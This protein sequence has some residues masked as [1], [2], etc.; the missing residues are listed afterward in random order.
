M[1]ASLQP[2]DFMLLAPQCTQSCVSRVAKA[3]PVILQDS[4]NTKSIYI[5]VRRYVKRDLPHVWFELQISNLL[6]TVE[7]RFGHAGHFSRG[8]FGT[9]SCFSRC[10]LA[11][12]TSSAMD[13][14]CADGH[15]DSFVQTLITVLTAKSNV[16]G[17]SSTRSHKRSTTA[18]SLSM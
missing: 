2:V 16:T 12:E 5:Y 9:G 14:L 8:T 10:S 18:K 3:F 7:S 1:S 6:S 4:A 15:D 17:W 11:R 13:S